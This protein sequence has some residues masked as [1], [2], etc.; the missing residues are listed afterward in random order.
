MRKHLLNIV[1]L[2]SCLMWATSSYGQAVELYSLTASPEGA[3]VWIRWEMEEETGISEY[4]LY[5]QIDVNSRFEQICTMHATNA[6]KYQF[7]DDDLFKD[8][9][10]VITYELQVIKNG[11][12]HKFYATLSHNPTA[13]QRTW[14][15]IKSMFQ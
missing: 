3:S 9:S 6:G 12:T 7:L 11:R 13:I 8:D 5:R 14:G 10:Q 4:R 1:L 15:S 2:L